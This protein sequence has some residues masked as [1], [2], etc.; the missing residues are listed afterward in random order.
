MPCNYK[1]CVFQV[2]TRKQQC[3]SN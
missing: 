1:C 2:Q 3:V